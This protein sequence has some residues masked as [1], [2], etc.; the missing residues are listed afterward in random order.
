MIDFNNKIESNLLN[1][2]NELDN[3]QEKYLSRIVKD[4]QREFKKTMETV[5]DDLFHVIRVHKKIREVI[6]REYA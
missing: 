4:D 1:I 2:T 6:E 5:R 3:I